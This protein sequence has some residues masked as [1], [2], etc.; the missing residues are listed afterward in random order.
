MFYSATNVCSR[1]KGNCQHEVTGLSRCCGAGCVVIC[2]SAE[3]TWKCR[4]SLLCSRCRQAW[5]NG[6]GSAVEV[7]LLPA[8]CQN[9]PNDSSKT[10]GS[11]PKLFHDSPFLTLSLIVQLSHWT[12]VC[13]CVCYCVCFHL[14]LLSHFGFLFSFLLVEFVKKNSPLCFLCFQRLLCSTHFCSYCPG[15]LGNFLSVCE[16]MS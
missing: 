16:L 14:F 9:T 6:M 11:V 2:G 10:S 12:S 1:S 7:E 4:C 15:Y 8:S 5:H 13:T 3:C